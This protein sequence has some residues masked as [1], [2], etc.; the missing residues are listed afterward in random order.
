[1]ENDI[2]L[3]GEDLF[4]ES[5]QPESRGKISDTFTIPPFSV[6]NAREGFWQDRKRAWSSLGIKSEVGR[7]A[8]SFNMNEWMENNGGGARADGEDTSIFDPVLTEISYK[9][10]CPPGGQVVDPF[11][12]GSVRG[13]VASLLGY[14]Y[15]GCDLRAEQI[16]ANIEQGHSIVKETHPLP[17]WV[18]ADAL[19]A[20]PDAPAADMIFSCP[21]YGSLEKYS[22]D[23]RDLS[24]M[25]NDQFLAAYRKIIQ[26]CYV[27]LRQ[28]RFACFVV[29]EYRLKNGVYA[30]F[31]GET[32]QAFLEA[33]FRY[34]N[35]AVLVTSVGSLP[36]RISKQFLGGRKLGKTH[37]NILVFVKGDWKVA[38]NIFLSST[39]KKSN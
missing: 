19:N 32:I 26:L 15:W 38:A 23:P 27:A 17:H 9:W 33:G 25:T 6:L 24:A 34:Y 39:H 36:V 11:A 18:C 5:I 8:K 2:K 4:G 28:D 13:V 35:E 20:I 37:Q 16:A 3:Y 29:G 12:G 10:F 22:D 21:P 7:S 1:M 31:I 14:H 30:N